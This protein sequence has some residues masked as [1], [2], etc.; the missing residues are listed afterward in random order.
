[1]YTRFQLLVLSLA[2]YFKKTRMFISTQAGKVKNNHEYN[3]EYN[4]GY[5]HGYNFSLFLCHLLSHVNLFKMQSIWVFGFH[6][7]IL[8]CCYITVQ[9]IT[10]CPRLLKKPCSQSNDVCVFSFSPMT[11]ERKRVK[12]MNGFYDIDNPIE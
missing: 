3:H 6:I 5:N 11:H 9:Y 10:L 8:H 7:N 2:T 1:M 4:H 12:S